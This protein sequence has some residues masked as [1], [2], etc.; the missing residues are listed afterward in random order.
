MRLLPACASISHRFTWLRTN[1]FKDRMKAMQASDDSNN[2]RY[3]ARRAR[4]SSRVESTAL[5]R[6]I[7]KTDA[8]FEFRNS[9]FDPLRYARSLEQALQDSLEL[10]PIETNI[11]L[12]CWADIFSQIMRDA[13]SRYG[14]FLESRLHMIIE[15]R[16]NFE[17]AHPHS[18]ALEATTDRQRQA[19]S[20]RSI[21]PRLQK[22]PLRNRCS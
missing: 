13:Y 21:S 7:R 5:I 3:L 2:V 16:Q 17:D 12:Q 15:A 4:S 1:D 22:N 19:S 6:S 18:L 20:H 14:H 11:V 9:A 8:T 10:T